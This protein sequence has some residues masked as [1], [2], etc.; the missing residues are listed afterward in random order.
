L[1]AIP[2]FRVFAMTIVDRRFLIAAPGRAWFSDAVISYPVRRLRSSWLCSAFVLA[3]LCVS[4]LTAAPG[5]EEQPLAARS[6]PRGKTLFVQLSPEDTGIRTENNYAGPEIWGPHNRELELGAIGTG[7]AIGDYD[8]DGRPDLFVVSKTETCRLFHNLGGSKFEDVTEKAG[9]GDHGDAAKI[10]KDGVTF[11]DINNDGRLDIYVCRFNA[12][13]LLYINQGDGTFKESAHAYGLDVNDAC[14]M[15]A[16]GDYDRDGWLDVFI[17]TNILDAVGHPEGQKDYLFHNNGDGT[18]TNVTA[19]SGVAPQPTHGNSAIWWDYDNDGWPDLYVTNDFDE[20]DALYHN[21]RDGTFTNVINRVVPH[22]PYSAMGSD[23]GDINNDGRVDFMVAD[24]A[25]SNHVA[26]QR[27][28]AD[29]RAQ[30]ADPDAAP[31][32]ARQFPASAVY[33]NTGTGRCLEVARLAGIAATDWTWSV[34]FEDLDNDGRLDLFLTN[35]MYRE[36]HNVDL[37]ARRMSADSQ[38][39]RMRMV[40]AS[41][42]FAQSHFAF[43]NLGDLQFENDSAAWGLDQKAVSFGAAFGDLD[44]DGDLDLVYSNFQAGATVLRNDSDTGH[45]ALFALRG[46]RSN[47]FG[48]GAKVRIET[49]SGVQVRELTLARGYMS[50]SDPV[51]HFGLGE[52]TAI[53]RLTIDWPSGA[54]QI[55]ENLPADRRFT[56]TE[57]AADAKPAAEKPAATAFVDISNA[58]NLSWKSTEDDFDELLEQRLL[59]IRQNRRGPAVAVGDVDGSGNDG[60]VIGATTHDPIR[61]LHRTADGKFS[62]IESPAL[63]AHPTVDDGPV[64]LLDARGT[65]HMDLLVT[66][67]GASLPAGSP[68]YQPALYFNSGDGHFSAAPPDA[69]PPLP[70]SAGAAAAADFNHDGHIDVFIG[71]RVSPGEYPHTPRS[72]LLANRGGKFEDVTDT[73]APALREVGMVTAALWSDVDGDGFPDLLLTLDWGG[74]K[75][76]HNAAGKTLEDWSEKAGFAAVGTGWWCAIA[77]GDF[78]GDGRPDYIVGNVGLNTPYRADAQHPAVLFASDFSGRGTNDIIE[79]YYEDDR[80]YPRRSRR[81]LIAA[82]PTLLRR[83]PKN[84]AYARATLAEVVGQDKLDAATRV[85]ATELQSGVFLSQPDGRY[86]FEPLPR[87]AQV[88]PIDGIVVADFDGDGHADIC[89]VE[90][91]Y[92]PVPAV[93]RFDGGLGQLLRGDGHGHFEAVPPA[94]SGI[95]V[96]GDAKALAIADLNGDGWPDLIASRNNDTTLAFRNDP[97]P[98]RHSLRVSLHGPTGNPTGI[99]AVVTA[100]FADGTS[101]VSEVCAGSGYYSQSSPAVWVAYRD[102][103]PLRHLRV[104]WPSG[105]TSAQDVAVGATNVTLTR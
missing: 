41:P 96:P 89:L 48:I 28:M 49:A 73:V 57:P 78:N 101:T 70:I 13:N 94:D 58:A 26:D 33:L 17:Q 61:V 27:T 47:R 72:A 86:V 5:I 82:I 103:N 9:V 11:V 23:L 7:V 90:N 56:V 99:G 52:D 46:T 83:F 80:L 66:R 34:R 74:V 6:G 54:Q 53:R 37:L 4:A 98:G 2:L 43:R 64:L 87:L 44:G 65:G 8:G 92:A 39:D 3:G 51:A 55:V 22:V 12:P 105:E 97:K 20:P 50:S 16:F 63:A 18:F 100:E 91:S 10:W 30:M 84:D 77:T 95:V 88:A 15:A 25:A 93:G 68:D 59:P 76:F 40:R 62:L 71:G 81:E 67:G 32:V 60:V 38:L 29:S 31:N 36:I 35:G 21:N 102:A 79:G 69:L 45:R 14:V 104:R 42:P 1:S 19:K 85:A 75:Y 24:M